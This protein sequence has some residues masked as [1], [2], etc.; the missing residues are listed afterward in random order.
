[1]SYILFTSDLIS[2]WNSEKIIFFI[3]RACRIFKPGDKLLHSVS[4]Q[5]AT[6]PRD[7]RVNLPGRFH[8]S[9]GAGPQMRTKETSKSSMLYTL[10]S[11]PPAHVRGRFHFLQL[12]E[13]F[14]FER[15]WA[16]RERS[17]NLISTH[18]ARSAL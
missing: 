3:C 18:V 13:R 9:N 5:H 17:A 2:P 12:K 15:E 8:S 1:M 4:F 14:S 6:L 16:F 7:S 11:Q 10:Q